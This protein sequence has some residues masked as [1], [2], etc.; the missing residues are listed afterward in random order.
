M[1][2]ASSAY[3]GLG[4]VLGAIYFFYLNNYLDRHRFRSNL[5]VPGPRDWLMNLLGQSHAHRGVVRTCGAQC[6]SCVSA[7]AFVRLIDEIKE[8]IYITLVYSF[9]Q[10]TIIQVF[11]VTYDRQFCLYTIGFCDMQETQLKRCA[12]YFMNL[13]SSACPLAL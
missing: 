2:T 11:P 10:L 9:F 3:M 4:H 8:N 7:V 5:L 1:Y 6:L 12:T 13:A